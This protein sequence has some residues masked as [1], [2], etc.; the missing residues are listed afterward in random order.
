MENW[1]T[2]VVALFCGLGSTALFWTFGV[3]VVVPWRE[4]RMLAL[5]ASELQVIA[6]PLLLGFL[7]GWGAL[8][9]LAIADR[10]KN[11]RIYAA[12]CILTGIIAVAAVK[13]GISWTLARIN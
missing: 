2:R 11:P 10:A 7:S 13:S 12:T 3:F 8:H 6:A 5:N 4:G 1:I 9:I